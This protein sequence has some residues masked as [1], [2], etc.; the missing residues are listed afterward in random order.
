MERRKNQRRGAD[1]SQFNTSIDK[2]LV[3]LLQDISYDTGIPMN[4]LIE[5]ALKEKYLKKDEK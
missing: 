4:R 5:D 1:R 3:A 2:K